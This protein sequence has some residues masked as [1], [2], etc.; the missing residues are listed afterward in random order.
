MKTFKILSVNISEEKG[1][2]KKPVRSIKLKKDFGIEGDAHAGSWHRQVSLL[3]KE[4]IDTMQNRGMK[5]S[6]GDFAENITTEGVN[7]SELPV[8][9]RLKI[10]KVELEVSQIGKECHKGCEIL[11]IVGDCVMPR[12]GIF[13][14]VITGGE[15]N[16]E[17]NGSY[18]F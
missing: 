17:S 1:K 15:I 4:D 11:K 5:I 2:K 8:G 12:K 3:A 7:L 16:D 13:A 10:E 6:F 14:K 9:S 18:S